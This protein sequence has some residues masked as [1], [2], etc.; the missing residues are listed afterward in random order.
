MPVWSSTDFAFQCLRDEQ[1]TGAYRSAIQQV[2]RRGDVVLDAGAGTGILALFAAAAG[3][4]R[5]YAVELDPWLAAALRR[6]I[7]GNGL[8]HVVG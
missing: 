7:E 2:V 8:E 1:R 4:R 3:A 6:T 5:V